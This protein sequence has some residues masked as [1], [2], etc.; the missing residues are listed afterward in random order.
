[1]ALLYAPMVLQK[2]I[3]IIKDYWHNVMFYMTLLQVKKRANTDV[4]KETAF[5]IVI[6]MIF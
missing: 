3:E 1:M 2:Y 6:Q 5:V 4:N